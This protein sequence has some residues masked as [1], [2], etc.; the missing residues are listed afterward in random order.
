MQP[1]IKPKGF[2]AGLFPLKA[3]VSDSINFLKKH[4]PKEGYFLGFS[5]GKDSIV[6]EHLAKLSKVKYKPYYTCTRIDPPEIYKFIKEH[7][8]EIEWC[9][10]KRSFWKLISIYAPPTIRQ[11]WCCDQIKKNPAFKKSPLKYRLMGI[12]F[13]ESSRRRKRKKVVE[14]YKKH[15]GYYMVKPI[16]HWKEWHIW[17]FID[18]YNLSYPKLYDE[19]FSRIGCVV[20]LFVFLN[21]K[22]MLLLQKRYPSIWKV[23]K[24]V[25]EKWYGKK[26]KKMKKQ[27]RIIGK[28]SAEEWYEKYLTGFKK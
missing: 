8:P 16:F 4:E 14:E 1:K 2:Q 22:Q 13:E 18:Q 12:R 25:C 28:W 15:P 27:K 21:K 7:Y 19:G 17:E 11:R 24:K 5:G 9:Y 26:K 3:M 20:C 23:H 6:L 10:S